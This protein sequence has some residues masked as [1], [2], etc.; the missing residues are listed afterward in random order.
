MR[1]SKL[2]AQSAKTAL[3]PPKA[4]PIACWMHGLA[5]LGLLAICAALY[6]ATLNLGFFSLDDPDYIQNNPFIAALNAANLRHIL[7]APYFANYAPGHLL[8]YALDA[9]LAGG[10]NAWAM[11]LANVL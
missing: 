11:H 4:V 3:P 6:G 8:S 9:A 2:S 1:R 5:A 7:S 10:K